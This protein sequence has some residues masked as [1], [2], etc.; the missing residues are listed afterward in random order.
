MPSEALCGQLQAFSAALQQ[1]V[2]IIT[3]KETEVC[4]YSIVT[5]VYILMCDTAA[6]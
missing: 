4:C 6:V 3:A 1:A 5:Y 2:E